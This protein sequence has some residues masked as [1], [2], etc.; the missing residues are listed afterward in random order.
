MNFGKSKGISS[1]TGGFLSI[2]M[3]YTV[4]VIP[5]IAPKIRSLKRL[6]FFVGASKMVCPKFSV[7]LLHPNPLALHLGFYFDTASCIDF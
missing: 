1:N 5:S 2:Q 6:E 4:Q 7:H 3:G